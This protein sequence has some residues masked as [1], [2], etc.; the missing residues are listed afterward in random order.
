MKKL[1]STNRQLAFYLMYFLLAGAVIARMTPHYLN[2]RYQWLIIVLFF[3]YILF[4][5]TER[6]ISRIFKPYFYIY[7]VMQVAI[8][9]GLLYIPSYTAPQ[10]YFMN[11]IIPLCGQAIWNL[12]NRPGKYLV[13]LFSAFC[14]FAMVVTYPDWEG[15]SFGFTYIVGC[16][17]VSVLSAATQNSHRAQLKSQALLDEL[18]TAN[19]KLMD[20]T[21]QVEQLAAAEERNR[22]ARELHDLVS[23]TIFSMTLTAQAAR[24]L[25]DK[26]PGRVPPLLDHLQ[27][28]SQNAL[29]EMRTLIQELRPHSI[30]E[31]GL[32]ETLRKH[33]AERQERDGLTI[34]LEVLGDQKLSATTE[35]GLFRIV[36]EAL[37]NVV[38]HAQSK[39][40]RIIAGYAKDFYIA[41]N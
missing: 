8:V 31:K 19:K 7:S 10:D 21:M 11:L 6:L 17:L 22:L 16:L 24:I 27:T 26:E 35:E 37:N 36:Q 13:V 40:V 39:I 32:V 2:T 1:F 34:T 20:F 18:Q 41:H 14:M 3:M 23:Q 12:P 25:Q 4:L 9:V 5:S 29:F 28:L 33:V 38:K 30:V 15:I